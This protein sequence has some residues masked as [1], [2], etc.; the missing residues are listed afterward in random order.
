MSFDLF[1]YPR[2]PGFKAHGTSQEA[3]EK[4]APTAAHLRARVLIAF[5]RAPDGLTADEAAKACGLDKLSVRPRCTELIRTHALVK[6]GIRRTNDSGM[7][8][9]VLKVA[10]GETNA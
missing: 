4:I 2:D 9:E 1:S 8:A 3:A 7:T 6:T 10:K 5:L